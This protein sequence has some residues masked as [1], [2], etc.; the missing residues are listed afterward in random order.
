MVYGEIEQIEQDRDGAGNTDKSAPEKK[1][2]G[3]QCKYW[4][5]TYNNYVLEQ[6]E[7]LDQVF[8]NEADWFVFQEEIGD[9]GTEH[10]QGVICF[11]KKKRLTECRGIWDKAIHWE[12]TKSVKSS[13]AYCSKC[14]SKK[15]D[16]KRWVYNINIPEEIKLNDIYGWQLEVIEIIKE[17]PDKRNIY[18]FWEPMGSMGKS[19]L[20]KYLVVKHNALM[21]SGK[22]SD[23]FHMISKFPHKRN[24][25]IYDLPR[26]FSK[27]SFD[28]G[29]IECVKNGLIFSGKYESNQCVFNSPHIF[30]FANCPPW[31]EENEYWSKDR[32]IVREII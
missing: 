17:I 24:L 16:G 22:G 23:A 9:S 25:L 2:Q 14:E 32:L 26:S 10:L 28:W 21:L 29:A 3:I 4:C 7:Q 20:C 6:I 5:F 1:K 19:E 8:K 13:V 12:A 18:W 31:G 30:I 11:K 27:S 15:I